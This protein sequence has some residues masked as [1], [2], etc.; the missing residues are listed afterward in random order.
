MQIQ[1]SDTQNKCLDPSE[2]TQDTGAW[3]RVQGVQ[4]TPNSGADSYRSQL[5]QVAFK[6]KL[7]YIDMSRMYAQ[8]KYKV[9]KVAFDVV[10]QFELD[11]KMVCYDY[12]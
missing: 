2:F 8:L 5:F 10:P 9:V 12:Y 6:E 4:F 11:I 3:S 7:H 1:A